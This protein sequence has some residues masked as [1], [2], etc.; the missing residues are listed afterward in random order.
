[1]QSAGQCHLGTNA[2]NACAADAD[3]PGTGA[4]CASLKHIIFIIKENRSFDHYFGGYPGVT[5]GWSSTSFPCVGTKGGCVSGT[6][7]PILADPTVGDRDIG[8]DHTAALSD[9]NGGAMNQFNKNASNSTDWAKYYDRTKIGYYWALADNY[10]LG[11]HMFA[12]VT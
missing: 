1:G 6:F 3:C 5:A 4:Y 12:S 7:T 10:G 2:G 11:D 8:H 9:I